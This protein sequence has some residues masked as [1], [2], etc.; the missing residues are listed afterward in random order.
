M[1]PEMAEQLKPEHKHHYINAKRL[2]HLITK[3]LL[4]L[5]RNSVL[6]ITGICTISPLLFDDLQSFGN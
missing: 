4:T 5:N 1:I 6:T 2:Y 3:R